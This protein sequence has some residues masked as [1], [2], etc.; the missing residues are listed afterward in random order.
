MRCIWQGSRKH[1]KNH[2][3]TQYVCFPITN[4]ENIMYVI[5]IMIKYLRGGKF[6]R[7]PFAIDSLSYPKNGPETTSFINGPLK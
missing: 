6:R 5:A 2:S 1:S 3:Q 7:G 4:S